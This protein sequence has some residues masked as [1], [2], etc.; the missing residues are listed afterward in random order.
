[1]TQ[2]HLRSAGATLCLSLLVCWITLR[3]KPIE[4]PAEHETPVAKAI[5]LSSPSQTESEHQSSPSTLLAML[6]SGHH[7]EML[8]LLLELDSDTQQ[9]WIPATLRKWSMRSPEEAPV[10][11]KLLHDNELLTQYFSPLAQGWAISA[12]NDLARFAATLPLG[13]ERSLGL[14]LAMKEW[15]RRNPQS[16]IEWIPTLTDADEF[17]KYLSEYLFATDTLNRSS[18]AAADL[19]QEIQNEALQLQSLQYVLTE[20]TQSDPDAA[21]Q[22]IASNERV[23]L[24]QKEQL[25]TFLIKTGNLDS[26]Q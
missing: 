19:A 16:A 15:I 9:E 25:L 4:L 8:E 5:P 3:Q 13:Q 7:L 22:F 18:R 17:D 11:A 12:P 14:N 2:R 21:L 20:W 1:M 24:H 10:L 6:N 26:I 23:E